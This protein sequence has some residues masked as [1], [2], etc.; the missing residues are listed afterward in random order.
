M[1][2]RRRLL[3][4]LG[5]LL[6]G[7]LAVA[8]LVQLHSLRSDIE[9]EVAASARLVEVLLA[10]GEAAP[11]VAAPLADSALRHLSIRPAGQAAVAA[12]PPS[13]LAWLGLVP[14]IGGEQQI[15][16]G[17]R[18]LV[19]APK[20]GSEID[21]RLGD[22]VRL[23]IT[24]LLFSGASLL[25][26]WFAADRALAPVR[27]LEAGLE[28]LAR[29]EADPALPAFA[30]R[31][32]SRVAGAIERLAADLQEARAAQ[33]ALARQLISVQEAERRSLAR[34]LHD[35]MGQTLTA[36]K[37]TATYLERNAGRLDAAGVADCA[38][39][40][41]RDIRSCGEQ[42]RAIL[43]TLRPH[44]LEA[45]GLA[46]ALRDLID[47]WRSRE[48]GIEFAVDLPT[49]PPPVDEARALALYRVVQEALTN[50]VRHSGAV[51]CRVS[52]ATVG[53]R[54][55][56]RVS[57]NGAGLHGGPAPRGGLL[58]MAER[59]DMAGG[60]LELGKGE[61]GGLSLRAWVPCPVAGTAT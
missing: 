5:L 51:H 18:S 39:D 7:L 27:E 29:G 34:E 52:L 10:A 55:E 36:L 6:G 50:V 24:L 42:L 40:L 57:D 54:I 37:L 13:W 20:P 48:T 47:G 3:T 26:A 21:E 16:I 15:R 53:N 56:A 30:L 22:T 44:G 35:D 43:K 49:S 28:R 45:A 9:A 38:A 59:V 14:E 17:E 19:I 12:P 46:E 33:R 61:G 11:D 1:D 2:L 41:R 25:V 4:R 8:M 58:G 31:E 60:G 32:F 23:L